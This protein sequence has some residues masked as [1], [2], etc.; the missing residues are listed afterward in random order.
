MLLAVDVGNTNVTFAAFVGSEIVDDWRVA[1]DDRRTADEYAVL[2]SGLFQVSGW[3][4]DAIDGFVI[5]SVVPRA[6][7]PL[8]RFA[9]KYLHIE[10]PLVLDANTP[11]GVPIKYQPPTDVGADRIANAVAAHALY[12]GPVI[13]VDF[14]TATTLDAI[15]AKG[16][17]L[18]G[19]IAPGIETSVEALAAKAAQL[20][21]VQFIRPASAIGSTTIESLQSGVIYGF[22]GQVDG[23][24]REFVREMGECTV[25]ATG[26]LAELIAPESETIQKVDPHLTL[27]GLRII[28]ERVNGSES[29]S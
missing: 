3:R 29:N 5:S 24:V 28:Y 10:N 14:G 26:G 13:V 6:I 20:R 1:T 23:L 16:E 22:A 2:L 27:V 11:T 9:D 7:H 12:G 8:R 4:L 17:Y 19:A 15:S 18:G 25:V 21:R